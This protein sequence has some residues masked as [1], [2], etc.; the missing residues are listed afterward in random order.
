MSNYGKYIYLQK[1]TEIDISN[2][3]ILLRELSLLHQI[4]P[5]THGFLAGQ[6][7][8]TFFLLRWN[9]FFVFPNS[10]FSHIVESPVNIPTFIPLQNLF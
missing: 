3:P 10:I 2:I 9:S 8:T 1:L 4:H 5:M 7:P 6:C